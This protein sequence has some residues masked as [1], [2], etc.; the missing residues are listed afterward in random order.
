MSVI[1]EVILPTFFIFLIGFIVQKWKKMNIVS[2]STVAVYI[3][4]PM[5]VFRTFYTVTLDQQYLYMTLF[6]FLLLGALILVN[7]IYSKL[8][9]YP[10]DVESA[11]ILSTAFMNAGNYGAPIVLFAFGDAG[12]AYAV[13]FLVLQSLIMNFFGVY[14]AAR[15]RQG[16]K[17]AIGAVFKMPITYTLVIGILFNVLKIPVP[18]GAYAAIDL[19][20]DAAIPVAMIILGMQLAELK[21]GRY[22]EKGKVLYGV[23]VRMVIS[24]LLTIIIMMLFPFDPL[25]KKVLIVST[26]MPTAVTTTMYA[27]QFNTLPMLVSSITFVTTV[28]SIFTITILLLLL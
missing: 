13:S 7:K 16:M 6:A 10:Q 14:Y 8:L 24:P 15:G 25:L 5:L 1:F 21:L 17:P 26:A 28:L 18:N 12:F 11:L 4:S 3:L 9:R 2:V 19:V 20:A 27:L 23:I 22:F